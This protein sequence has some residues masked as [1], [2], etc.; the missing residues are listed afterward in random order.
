MKI[1]NG[2]IFDDNVDKF[3]DDITCNRTDLRVTLEE[4]IGHILL[5][6]KF[7]HNVFFLN[8]SG[9]NGKST[10][11]T[12]LSNF[13]KDLTS[14]IS[15]SR[16]EDDTSILSLTGKMLNISDDINTS[17]VEKS[18]KLK[19]MSAGNELSIRPIYS[20]SINFKNTATFILTANELPVFKDKSNG[21]YRRLLMIPF[22]YKVDKRNPNL[23]TLLSTD[24]AKSYI[25]NVALKGL[26]RIIKNGYEMTENYIVK[27]ATEEYKQDTD[28]IYAYLQEWFREV[29]MEYESYC[30]RNDKESL[31]RAVFSRKLKVY[32]YTTGKE[33]RVKPNTFDSSGKDRLIHKLKNI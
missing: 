2:T 17:Y 8:G 28:S 9:K 7:P 26:G 1:R 16:F 27:S 5:V 11:V 20:G 21:M 30:I 15:L 31:P 23:D 29:Y 22:D 4:I 32:S 19:L 24:N 10:F 14:H 12:M 25:L 13:A 33:E 18:E 6:N 3:L